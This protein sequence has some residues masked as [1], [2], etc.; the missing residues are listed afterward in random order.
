M[1]AVEDLPGA[2]LAELEQLGCPDLDCAD[3]T[4]CSKCD[5]RVCTEHTDT[6]VDCACGSWHHEDCASDCDE[7]AYW[8]QYS[9]DEDRLSD[10]SYE[11][12]AGDRS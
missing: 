8:E 10:E 3:I 9:I 11:V 6:A 5:L 4:L 7:F 2:D 12:L 1:T